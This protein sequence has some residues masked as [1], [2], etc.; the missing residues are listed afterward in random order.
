MPYPKKANPKSL[1]TSL[2][3]LNASKKILQGKSYATKLGIDLTKIEF[4]LFSRILALIT[5]NEYFQLFTLS[6]RTVIHELDI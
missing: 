6:S 3:I 4:Q 5:L 1:K 2:K